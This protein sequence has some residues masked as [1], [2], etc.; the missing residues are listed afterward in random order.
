ME[1]RAPT[2]PNPI[3][4]ATAQTGSNV[5]T[6]IANTALNN[7]NVITPYGTT[8]T[9]QTGTQTITMPDGTTRDV[10]T[11]T[12]TQSLTPAEQKIFDQQQGL[13]S[14]V[15]T[16]AGNQI[17]FLTD[18][19]GRPIST[20]G[21]PD[22][23]V[24]PTSGPKFTNIQ[25]GPEFTNIQGGPRFTNAT[26]AGMPIQSD[27][28]L[29]TTKGTFAGS[30]SID[31]AVNLR[32]ASTTFKNV[33]GPQRNVGPTDFS[34]DRQAVTDALLSRVNPMLERDESALETKLIGQ[35]FVPGTPAFTE[36]MRD[37]SVRV[38]DARMG[39]IL[40]GGQEQSRLAGLDFQQFGLEN[41]AQAQA[42]DQEF[43]RG[44]FARDSIAQ[45]NAT[46]I[47]GADF[48]N[49]AQQQKFVQD[50]S[51]GRFGMDATAAN[52]AAA[53]AEGTFRNQAQGQ[54][55]GQARDVWGF[56][57]DN[58]QRAW[59]NYL[60]ETGIN[61]DTA[62]R[63]WQNYLTETGANN[64]LSQREVANAT[65]LAKMN[66]A[67]RQQALAELVQLRNQPINEISA[68]MSGGQAIPYQ[69]APFSGGQV[70][71]TPVGQYIYSSA[72]LDQ[73]NYQADQQAN[74]A[75]MGGLFGAAGTGLYG[76]MRYGFNPMQW[77]A[78]A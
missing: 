39:A 71:T 10:P 15:N 73:R 48:A 44:A 19:L 64:D 45:N 49:R 66:D 72:D 43:G 27:I 55:F 1:R 53:L 21:L 46:A 13:R 40:A 31:K 61:N 32:N 14:G 34:A 4:T 11:Y 9:K 59:Q 42:Y 37:H 65:E 16:L 58:A 63:E 26:N 24:L 68:L 47:A 7:P 8:T 30:G 62:Q 74:A 3:T 54:R 70:A 56:N 17:K 20:E 6:A 67:Q 33:G 50:E 60:T 51:R 22:R 76:G 77:G 78:R 28:N 75:M 25:G 23:G 2:P 36:A 69:G 5:E 57:N 38:N 12:Q 52:N 35:G 41:A 29:D 18:H